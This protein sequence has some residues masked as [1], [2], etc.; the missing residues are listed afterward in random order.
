MTVVLD[1]SAVLSV[2]LAENGADVVAEHLSAARLGSV[3]MSEI[4]AKLM[5]YGLSMRDARRQIV[6]LELGI[7]DFDSDQAE[8]SALLRQPTR[9]LGL[10]LGDRACLALGQQLGLPIL[11]AD[12]RMAE[13]KSLL[14]IDIRLIR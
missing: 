5:E 7:H 1:A 6:R 3:N 2:L 9:H 14:E 10:S 8:R 13:A 4:L 12:R 11:T